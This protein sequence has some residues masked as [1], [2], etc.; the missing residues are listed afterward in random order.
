MRVCRS[1]GIRQTKKTVRLADL[2]PSDDAG[3][4]GVVDVVDVAVAVA[5]EVEEE[6]QEAAAAAAVVVM[7]AVVEFCC[8]GCCDCCFDVF[9]CC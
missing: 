3:V 8:R 6:E 7:E 5:V 9:S 4:L 1:V 2:H